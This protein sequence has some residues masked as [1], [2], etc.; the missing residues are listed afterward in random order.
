MKFLTKK[1]TRSNIKNFVSKHASDGKT[2]D[3]GCASSV[4]SKYFPNRVGLDIKAGAGV[5]VVADAHK[6]PFDDESFNIVLC[7]EVLEHLHSPEIA[8]NE[9]ERVLIKGGKLI[10]TTR[11]IFPIH[12]A[13]NDYFRYTKYG[14]RHLFSGWDILGIKEEISTLRTIAVLMQRIGYQTKLK[15]G[16]FS[17]I[18]VF[19]LAK[20][21]YSL[22]WMVKEEFG[23]IKRSK[24]EV[25][26]M[27]SGYYIIC[28]K[29]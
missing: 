27:T 23:D 19:L 6:L 3:I 22:D 8:I 4:Y 25:G 29:R 9:M 16:K 21:I 10:L 2:L 20:L 12:E 26:I 1:L 17:K 24:K 11:F 28:Q 14:L 18:I 7:T 5:D 13:P 15:G